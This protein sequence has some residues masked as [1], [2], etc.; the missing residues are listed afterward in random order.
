VTPIKDV[1]FNGTSQKR[2][3]FWHSAFKEEEKVYCVAGECCTSMSLMAR[4]FCLHAT[5]T[6]ACIVG[7]SWA[8]KNIPTT[9]DLPAGI[10]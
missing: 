8:V 9:V 3:F 5:F 2:V 4:I 7:L 10:R 6:F 1:E